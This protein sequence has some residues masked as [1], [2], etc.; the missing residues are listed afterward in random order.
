MLQRQKGF[1]K[2]V[3]CFFVAMLIKDI[4][5]LFPMSFEIFRYAGSCVQV[6]G[7]IEKSMEGLPGSLPVVA[8]GSLKHAKNLPD[9]FVRKI[10]QEKP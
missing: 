10:S 2:K 4:I 3:Q 9:F 7:N 8:E 6:K 1:R 5:L